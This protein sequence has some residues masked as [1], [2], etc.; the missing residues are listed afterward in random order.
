MP[1]V[2]GGHLPFIQVITMSWSPQNLD[3]KVHDPSTSPEN[4]RHCYCNKARDWD[5]HPFPVQN[6][7]G[8][9]TD[10]G[11]S[12]QTPNTDRCDKAVLSRQG[13]FSLNVCHSL[14]PIMKVTVLRTMAEEVENK[15]SDSSRG[16]AFAISIPCSTVKI[17]NFF[18]ILVLGST[19]SEAPSWY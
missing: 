19:R 12:L 9:I 3:L 16:H 15:G 14:P 11:F 7:E 18:L 17:A 2:D 4:L 13:G 5:L 6:R 10:W 1:A 8:G